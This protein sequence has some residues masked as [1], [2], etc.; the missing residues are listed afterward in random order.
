MRIQF[1]ISQ[2]PAG[3]VESSVPMLA[4]LAGGG[5]AAPSVLGEGILEIRLLLFSFRLP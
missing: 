2:E 1:P 4:A 3:D 5:T